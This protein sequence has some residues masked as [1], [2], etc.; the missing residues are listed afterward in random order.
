[1]VRTPPLSWRHCPPSHPRPAAA[2]PPPPLSRPPSLHS[3][4][5]VATA[6]AAA[7]VTWQPAAAYEYQR[8]SLS[9]SPSMQASFVSRHLLRCLGWA[10]LATLASASPE[11][12]RLFFTATAWPAAETRGRELDLGRP[13]HQQLLR[14]WGEV[15]H[16]AGATPR[17][18]FLEDL[19]NFWKFATECSRDLTT[20][21]EHQIRMANLRKML[22]GAI[23][24]PSF[25]LVAT[26]E[27]LNNMHASEREYMGRDQDYA[28][29]I[30][31]ILERGKQ[32]LVAISPLLMSE[33][34]FR[35]RTHPQMDS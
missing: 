7:A 20:G 11:Y 33:F 28:N 18:P 5:D 13:E 6:V 19:A 15:W 35:H 12:Y 32:K 4:C 21:L 29:K 26:S 31:Q 27:E 8:L 23:L 30:L 2:P 14:V 17:V 25:R 9:T 1:M 24:N 16:R 10:D 3:V 22:I 34:F